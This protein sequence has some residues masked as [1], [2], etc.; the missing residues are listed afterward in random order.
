[1]PHSLHCLTRPLSLTNQHFCGETT[2]RFCLRS[3]ARLVS[4]AMRARNNGTDR[5]MD[6][7]A[8]EQRYEA[9]VDPFRQFSR[10]EKQRKLNEM[11]P[12]EK[13]V[14][15]VA[16]TVLGSKEMRTAL[17]FYVSTLHL[18]VFATT[19]HWSHGCHAVPLYSAIDELH[20]GI[21]NVV[22]SPP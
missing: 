11:S 12:V 4:V 13:T 20:A 9:S 2:A 8:L 21:P 19:Y 15:V 16:R 14:F 3:G 10:N 1:M 6:L 7:E 18:L 22:D 5:D 17:F